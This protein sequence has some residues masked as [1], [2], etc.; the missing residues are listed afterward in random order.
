MLLPS[1]L[2]SAGF[3][4]I[5]IF[6][7]VV[8]IECRRR[9]RKTRRRKTRK[10]PPVTEKVE[11]K[12]DSTAKKDE[13][14]TRK[15]RGKEKNNSNVDIKLQAPFY[16]NFQ[17]KNSTESHVVSVSTVTI[18]TH[19][20]DLRNAGRL[21]NQDVYQPLDRNF[22]DSQLTG[23]GIYGNQEN[24]YA[25]PK[26]FHND[27]QSLGVQGKD[28]H[29]YQG[30]SFKGHSTDEVES[31]ALYDN[32]S[33]VPETPEPRYEISPSEENETYITLIS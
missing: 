10:D 9:N 16:D 13:K 5:M 23:M 28:D 24:C 2:G 17:A 26:G 25:N 7:I 18:E 33:R 21:G 12:V 3:I 29:V 27:Y 14:S 22:K 11:T 15:R 32:V 20:S 1:V 6:V 8:L 19:Y 4:L 31:P 30:L